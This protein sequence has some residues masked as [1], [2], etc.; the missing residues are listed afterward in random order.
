VVTANSCL[1]PAEP[2]SMSEITDGTGK[3]IIVVEV[4]V[5]QAVHWMSPKDAS[6]SLV[7]RVDPK[8]KHAHSGGIHALFVDGSVKFLNEQS[9]AT[10][11]LAMISIAGKEP[12][13]P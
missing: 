10:D 1:R 7:L 12:V 11:R 6:E 2:R 9:S 8:T 13:E 4:D 3:T 5:D